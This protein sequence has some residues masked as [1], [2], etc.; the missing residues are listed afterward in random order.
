MILNIEKKIKL[1]F[2]ISAGSFLTS[3][4]LV[5]VVCVFAYGLVNE[6]RK[7]IYV[8]DH[9]VPV[10]VRQS[11]Q[12]T[13]REVEYK[14]HVNMFHLL[15]F[16]LPPDDEYIKA[17]L[18]KAMYLIDDTGLAQYNNL[19]EKGYYNSILASSALLTIQTD[20]ITVDEK[21]HF[22]YYARQRIE[23]NTSIATRALITEGD[24]QEVP[25]TDNNPHG[26]IIKNWKTVL[27]KDLEY[28]EKKSF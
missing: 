10:L 11:E 14:S 15:F 26:L 28:V 24:L 19:K 17:N 22:T 9:N 12:G 4:A 3:V 5:A 16:T 18:A 25:R 21:L 23:R 1:A 7:S 2:A 20:S 6:Q 13:N 27:N 8:L